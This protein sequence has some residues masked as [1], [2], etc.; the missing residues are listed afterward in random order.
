MAQVL[1]FLSHTWEAK[2]NFLA[3]GFGLSYLSACY[4]T[5][6]VKPV[7]GSLLCLS[8]LQSDLFIYL[9]GKAI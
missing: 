6:G 5:W 1:G 9:K 2:I 8:P 4:T 3:P 7:E